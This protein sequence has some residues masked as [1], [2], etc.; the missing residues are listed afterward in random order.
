MKYF[1]IESAV[2]DAEREPAVVSKH[3]CPVLL[4]A[5]LAK[6]AADPAIY[7]THFKPQEAEVIMRQITA[8]VPQRRA[9][10]LERNQVFEF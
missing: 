4:V 10:M 5:E 1:I 2:A 8:Q 9:R 3:L 6:L 7:V